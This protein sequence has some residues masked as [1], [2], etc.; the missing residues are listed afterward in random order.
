MELRFCPTSGI[1]VLLSC[2]DGRACE[3]ERVAS[4]MPPLP[5]RGSLDERQQS[6]PAMVVAVEHERVDLI[7]IENRLPVRLP[8]GDVRVCLPDI[9]R[10]N[11]DAPVEEHLEPRMSR[12]A[13]V[14]APFQPAKN[15]AA[16]EMVGQ[17]R[18]CFMDL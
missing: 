9:V 6:R 17:E 7:L 2:D 14:F 4:L 3:H 10:I 18:L 15:P 16:L 13:Q 5:L 1:A 8:A 11:L 12:P